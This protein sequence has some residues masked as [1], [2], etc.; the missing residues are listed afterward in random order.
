MVK[1][2]AHGAPRAE[3]P[4]VRERRIPLAREHDVIDEADAQELAREHEPLGEGD[5]LGARLGL[6]ARVVVELN[7]ASFMLS[8]DYNERGMAAYSE[9]QQNEFAAEKQGYTA[10]KHQHEVGTGYFD[11]I[12]ELVS[13]GQRP[14][15]ES[16]TRRSTPQCEHANRTAIAR[17]ARAR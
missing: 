4:E 12:G 2:R 16:P 8:S 10:T 3:Q 6:A 11:V 14:L 13:Q 7:C 17:R 15:H 1:P 9:L 5:V